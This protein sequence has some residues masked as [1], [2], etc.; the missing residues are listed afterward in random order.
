MAQGVSESRYPRAAVRFDKRVDELEEK[1]KRTCQKHKL[2]FHGIAR[3]NGCRDDWSGALLLF[4]PLH[5]DPRV[6]TRKRL[7]SFAR[8]NKAEA[9]LHLSDQVHSATAH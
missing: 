2:P 4:P 5:P 6:L 8:M 3:D 7:L 9:T 1:L